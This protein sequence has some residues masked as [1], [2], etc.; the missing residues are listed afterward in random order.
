MIRDIAMNE[1]IMQNYLEKDK[2]L[3]FNR[4]KKAVKKQRVLKNLK[5]SFYYSYE[6]FLEDKKK[7]NSFEAEQDYFKELYHVSA[8]NYKHPKACSCSMCGNPRNN[9][10]TNGLTLKELAFLDKNHPDHKKN[11]LE[12]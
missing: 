8:K 9:G 3:A 11:W 1:V 2:K 10:W 5:G 12:E 6:C 4:Y 7:E